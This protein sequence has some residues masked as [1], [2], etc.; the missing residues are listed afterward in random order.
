MAGIISR[1]AHSYSYAMC[2]MWAAFY[3]LS[4]S[5]TSVPPEGRPK[6]IRLLF[7][8]FFGPLLTCMSHTRSE[9]M[10]DVIVRESLDGELGPG[11]GWEGC[12]LAPIC[13]RHSLIAF[14]WLFWPFYTSVYCNRQ[15]KKLYS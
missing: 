10:W 8:L 12:H 15:L 7:D 1:V 6:T 11:E 9:L 5:G 4:L 3:D 2:D 14:Q 13:L